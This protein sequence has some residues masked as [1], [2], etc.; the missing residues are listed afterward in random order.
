M[1]KKASQDLMSEIY[2]TT[3]D[4]T[5]FSTNTGTEEL[6]EMADVINKK[7]K[8]DPRLDLK[9]ELIP[10]ASEMAAPA[11]LVYRLHGDTM[12]FFSVIFAAYADETRVRNM[13]ER[14]NGQSIEI[15][16]P[17]SKIYNQ[18]FINFCMNYLSQ[19][20]QQP[21]Q[22]IVPTDYMVIE[23]TKNLADEKVMKPQA[24]LAMQT[25]HTAIS[26]HINPTPAPAGKA[27]A[28]DK[29]DV[30][31]NHEINPTRTKQTKDGKLLCADAVLD[32]EASPVQ[33]KRQNNYDP[34]T[35]PQS[36]PL[37]RAFVKLDFYKSPKNQQAN[38][39]YGVQMNNAMPMPGYGQLLV[40]TGV[41]GSRNDSPNSR[42]SFHS[43]ACGVISMI[44]LASGRNTMSML[45]VSDKNHPRHAG[46]FGY[47]WE[48]FFHMGKSHEPRL[49][50]IEKSMAP[51]QKADLNFDEFVQAYFTGELNVCMDVIDGSSM[52]WH[53][54]P[55]LEAAKGDSEAN[56]FLINTFDSILGGYFLPEWKKVSPDGNSPILQPSITILHD[57][58]F[59]SQ[60]GTK[61]ALTEIDYL[62]TMAKL[63]E[64]SVDPSFGSAVFS[65]TLAPNQ[66]TADVLHKR[67]TDILNLEPTAKVTGIIRRLYFTP[68]LMP[69]LGAAAVS[70]SLR[71]NST[72]LYDQKA[73]PTQAWAQL[74]V[75]YTVDMSQGQAV[76][77]P[78][79]QNGNPSFNHGWGMPQQP[80][81]FQ[82]PWVGR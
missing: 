71:I 73:N 6:T 38:S 31:L 17:A 45:D 49:L 20:T 24:M 37:S 57:G 29:I 10:D 67:R 47:D 12:Y 58:E 46:L 4:L 69:A 27:L 76:F 23:D 51:S 70:A 72:G 74:P 77:A 26:N 61:H 35:R 1:D 40:L 34:N 11:L 64:Q 18:S 13:E 36:L 25:A 53:Q 59:T 66:S 43:T 75:G 19:A 42:E 8:S 68:S 55:W 80:Q 48:P 56:K 2:G 41:E 81:G 3:G 9:I 63:K 7:L 16:M 79:N 15:D 21:V 22:K 33:N 62:Y 50:K 14:V 60:D 44:Q 39:G 30:T 65:G 28:S 52:A 32:L 54:R 5:T 82:N 78:Q